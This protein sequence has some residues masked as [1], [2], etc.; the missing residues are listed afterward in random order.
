MRLR[1]PE[2]EASALMRDVRAAKVS[3]KLNGTAPREEAPRDTNYLASSSR[4]APD[5]HEALISTAD[6]LM[7]DGHDRPM[8]TG[9]LAWALHSIA[10]QIAPS[11]EQTSKAGAAPETGPDR[12]GLF[13]TPAPE[14]V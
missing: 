6:K 2:A 3:D 14:E 10:R 13:G 7:E 11:P 5:L 9:N 1:S 4:K 8:T 12:S